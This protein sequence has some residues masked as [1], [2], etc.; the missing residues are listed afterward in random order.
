MTVLGEAGIGKSRLS[1]VFADSLAGEPGP[2]PQLASTPAADG[3]LGS[4]ATCS[5]RPEV[6]PTG[7]RLPNYWTTTSPGWATAWPVCWDWAS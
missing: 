4:S 7:S 1:Q 2:S 3:P 5:S 6:G